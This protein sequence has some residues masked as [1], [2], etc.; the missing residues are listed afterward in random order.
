VTEYLAHSDTPDYS[1]T[2]KMHV[3][4]RRGSGFKVKPE[5]EQIDGKSFVFRYGWLI[6]DGLYEGEAAWLPCV[7]YYPVEAPSWLASGD[8]I[9]T[10]A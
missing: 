6:E 5:A 1:S 4:L 3:K 7:S 9:D 2:R 10:G 8:L